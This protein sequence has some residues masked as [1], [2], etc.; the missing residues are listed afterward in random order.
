MDRFDKVFA[1]ML[2]IPVVGSV[3][4]FIATTSSVSESVLVAAL[5]TVCVIYVWRHVAKE[6]R[7]L[8]AEWKLDAARRR[9]DAAAVAFMRALDNGVAGSPS[10]WTAEGRELLAAWNDYHKELDG[11]AELVRRLRR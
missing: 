6:S 9:F 2:T 11:T 1:W 8:T 5:G 3:C 7:K 4:Y 10:Q